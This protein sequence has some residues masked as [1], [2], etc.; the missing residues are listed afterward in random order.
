MSLFGEGSWVGERG[1]V[2][3]WGE[4]ETQTLKS[5]GSLRSRGKTEWKGGERVKEGVC[6][7]PRWDV[8]TLCTNTSAPLRQVPQVTSDARDFLIRGAEPIGQ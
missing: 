2:R 3:A 6:A 1:E 5:G 4:R 8:Q 7:S